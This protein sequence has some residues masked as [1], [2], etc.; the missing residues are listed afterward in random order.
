MTSQSSLASPIAA[1]SIARSRVPAWVEQG[2]L[3]TNLP[4][5]FVRGFHRT[6][7]G[8]RTLRRFRPADETLNR[9]TFASR[10]RVNSRPIE[11]PRPRLPDLFTIPILRRQRGGRNAF[12]HPPGHLST[13]AGSSESFLCCLD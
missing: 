13:T 2:V 9:T 12:Q 11:L 3:R 4:P 7:F 8:S 1:G 5:P 10:H 6:S